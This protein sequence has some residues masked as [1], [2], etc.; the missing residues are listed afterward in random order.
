M[1]AR[2]TLHVGVRPGKRIVTENIV[3]D[4]K[5]FFIIKKPKE[6]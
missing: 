3:R 2:G 5:Q 4:M 1:N 6:T